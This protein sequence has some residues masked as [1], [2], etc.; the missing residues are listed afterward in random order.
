MQSD[1]TAVV[2]SNE[3]VFIAYAVIHFCG[4]QCGK[5]NDC[6]LQFTLDS[7]QKTADLYI[8]QCKP[9]LGGHIRSCF[10]ARQTQIR[11]QR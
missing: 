9:T 8:L 10:T 5:F 7:S 6:I 4:V 1:I 11:S 3:S 2:T